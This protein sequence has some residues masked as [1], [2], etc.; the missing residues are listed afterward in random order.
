MLG[1]MFKREV[2]KGLA[3]ARRAVALGAEMAA[4]R[5]ELAKLE[6]EDEKERMAMVV[7]GAFIALVMTVLALTF[8]GAFFIVAFWDTPWR[9]HAAGAVALVMVAGLV[10]AAAFTRSKLHRSEEAFAQL[11]RELAMDLQALRDAA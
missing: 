11:R 10:A 3:R 1:R 2:E 8:V 5:I 6:W 4:D 7:V 9:V